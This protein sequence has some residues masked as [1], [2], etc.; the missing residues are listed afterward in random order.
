MKGP[1]RRRL[2]A[3]AAGSAIGLGVLGYL[4][5]ANADEFARAL[6]AAGAGGI[7]LACLL[8]APSLALRFWAFDVLVAAAGAPVER[9]ASWSIGAISALVSVLNIVL[10]AAA[11]V[12]LWARRSERPPLAAFVLAD[13]TFLALEGVIAMLLLLVAS[14]TLPVS[15]LLPAV[16]ALLVLGGL[17]SAWRLGVIGRLAPRFPAL[18]GVRSVPPAQLARAALLICASFAFQVARLWLCLELVGVEASLFAAVLAFVAVGVFSALPLGASA[19]PAALLVVFGSEG[20]GAA[21]AAGTV[22]LISSLL[23]MA[24]A[25]ACGAFSLREIR[26]ATD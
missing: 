21:V 26:A 17:F 11:R 24:V 19:G 6:A 20:V 22:Y 8:H 12:A 18:A 3:T 10:G 14:S 15:P 13:G 16:V 7:A 4:G 1:E 23:T 5:A 2:A 25:A 9:R